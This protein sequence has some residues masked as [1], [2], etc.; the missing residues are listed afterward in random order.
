MEGNGDAATGAGSLNIELTNAPSAETNGIYQQAIENGATAVQG[1]G[2][3]A[4][5]NDITTGD[6]P[7]VTIYFFKNGTA[8]F[9]SLSVLQGQTIAGI[10][11]QARALAKLIVNK[12]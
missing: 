4:A 11:S 3:M 12:I 9:L 8:G 7:E 2:D 5:E 6:G 1:I 10:S